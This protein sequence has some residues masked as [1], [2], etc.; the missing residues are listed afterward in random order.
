MTLSSLQCANVPLKTTHWDFNSM[1][2]DETHRH[3]HTYT[4]PTLLQWA[5]WREGHEGAKPPPRLLDLPLTLC[6]P[7]MQK[8]K[9]KCTI[10]GV[11]VILLKFFLGRAQPLSIPHPTGKVNTPHH[12]TPLLRSPVTVW[13]HFTHCSTWTTKQNTEP[14]A[15]L[16]SRSFEDAVKEDG[17]VVYRGAE[18]S[19]ADSRHVPSVDSWARGQR[20]TTTDD[21]TTVQRKLRPSSPRT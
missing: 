14:R 12:S 16:T 19:V 18:V 4:R 9:L 20:Q 5:K 6:S 21:K 2:S 15:E 3:T 11:G 17:V 13:A 8:P 7:S 1:S 10:L